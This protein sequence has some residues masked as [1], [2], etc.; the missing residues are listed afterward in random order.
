MASRVSEQKLARS[1]ILAGR[2]QQKRIVPSGSVA[3]TG[4][5]A[6]ERIGP[7]LG[8]V[9]TRTGRIAGILTEKGV[10]LTLSGSL[11]HHEHHDS[12]EETRLNYVFPFHF[13]PLCVPQVEKLKKTKWFWS[14]AS[15]R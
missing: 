1:N 12:T 6:C 14:I 9:V 15:C 8:V 2:V 11:S 3:A 7:E 5:A 4:G 13:A 10:A